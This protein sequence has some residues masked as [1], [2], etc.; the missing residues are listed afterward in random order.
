MQCN[1]LTNLLTCKLANL[2]TRACGLTTD[3]VRISF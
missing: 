1:L 3:N 2:Q